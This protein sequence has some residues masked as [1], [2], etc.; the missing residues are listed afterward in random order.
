MCGYFFSLT[1]SPLNNSQEDAVYKS[2]KNRGPDDFGVF[3]TEVVIDKNKYYLTFLHTRLSIIDLS[4]AG[5]QPMM[6]VHSRYIL[7]YNGEIYNYAELKNKLKLDGVHFVSQT[8]SEVLLQSYIYYG[9]K[10]LEELRG[11][12]SFVIWDREKKHLFFARDHLGIKPL[13]YGYSYEKNDHFGEDFFIS[14][15]ISALLSLDLFNGHH[16]SQDGLKEYL[17]L[18]HCLSPHTIIENIY[19]LQPGF[20]GTM[21][22]GPKT[23]ELK[24]YFHLNSLFNI[25]ESSFSKMSFDEVK[26]DIKKTLIETVRR[27][28][29]ADVPIGMMLSGGIDSSVLACLMSKEMRDVNLHTWTLGFEDKY[30]SFDERKISRKIS[31]KIKS[32]HSEVIVTEENFKDN[33]EEFIEAIDVP[34]VDGLN[35]FFITKTIGKNQKIVISGM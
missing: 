22:N 17:T 12:F 6:D 15:E 26:K 34:S 21:A 27:H 5:H 13:Y 24:S 1:S 20:K 32:H 3:R 10:I 31:E 30:G 9:E 19:S 16:I 35:T 2:L 23:L 8:D 33:F 14:S 11:M 18:G 25:K 28:M 7:I 4:K 29:I